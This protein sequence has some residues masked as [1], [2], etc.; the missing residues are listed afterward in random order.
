MSLDNFLLMLLLV[1][2]LTGLFTEAIKKVLDEFNKPYYSN[3]LAG[4]VAAVVAILVDVGYII[5]AETAFNS[6]M[7]VFLIALV[8]LSWL[9]AMVGYDKVVQAITQFKNKTRS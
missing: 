2:A 5:L 6:K 3:L 1:S 4:I 9:C 7:A 8:L